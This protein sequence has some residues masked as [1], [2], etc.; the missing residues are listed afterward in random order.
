MLFHGCHILGLYCAGCGQS[1][2]AD[3]RERAGS[4]PIAF[5]ITLVAVGLNGEKR[6]EQVQDCQVVKR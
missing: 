4:V 6:V 1:F 2:K 5:A 3:E